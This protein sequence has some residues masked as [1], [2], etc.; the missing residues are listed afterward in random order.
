MPLHE[1]ATKIHFFAYV[2][3]TDPGAVGAKK[4]WVDTS[5]GPPYQLYVRNSGNTS[6]DAVG[7]VTGGGSGTVTSVSLAM[8]SQFGVTGSPVT[9]SGGFTVTWN[10]EAANLI[11]AGP[12]SGGSAVP[13][14]RS[15]VA[16]DL[17]ATA[18]TPGSYTNTNLTVDAQGRITAAANGSGGGGGSTGFSAVMD[19]LMDAL[20]VNADPIDIK[21]TSGSYV[22]FAFF[23]SRNTNGWT[24]ATNATHVVTSGKKLVFMYIGWGSKN[25]EDTSSS[26]NVRIYNSTDSV[27]VTSAATAYQRY[28]PYV[29]DGDVAVT[30]K[31][32]EVA[33]GKTVRLEIFNT[34][35]VKRASGALVIGKEV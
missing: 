30:S 19:G 5:S 31:F 16:A 34:D 15:L 9:T 33:S 32:P 28:S 23:S 27:Q 14:F 4:G 20:A 3:A 11:F 25:I 26:R 21:V 7:I 10:T 1:N 17:P 2:A 13:T 8:P 29:W 35:G 6:W 18:V 24:A 12:S 22:G